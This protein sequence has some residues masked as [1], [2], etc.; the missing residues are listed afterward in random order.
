MTRVRA[1]KVKKHADVL[2]TGAI[3][4][5][6]RVAPR[7]VEKWITDGLLDSYRIP[8]SSRK[9]V[10]LSVVVQFARQHGLPWEVPGCNRLL[11]VSQYGALIGL[12]EGDQTDVVGTLFEA[13]VC[14]SAGI[15][16]AVVLDGC[17]GLSD[18]VH[19]AR[20]SRARFPEA[21]C[22]LVVPEDVQGDP[23][24]GLCPVV[25]WP[26]GASDILNRVG[27]KQLV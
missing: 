12:L 1:P 25:Q 14:L 7:T 20:V 4:K 5:M 26:A 10:Q 23:T 21:A 17:M 19:A 16:R 13:G 15:Y 11:V 2:T 6:F 8:G 18:M 9:M 24:E 22:V 27:I 3:A